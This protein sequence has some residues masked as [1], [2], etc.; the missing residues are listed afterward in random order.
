MGGKLTALAAS[1]VR[2]ETLGRM[3]KSE[4]ISEICEAIAREFNPEKIIV[5]GSHAY[6]T[7]GPFADLDLI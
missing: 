7:P 3:S 2:W 4:Q 5:F 6:G 1:D